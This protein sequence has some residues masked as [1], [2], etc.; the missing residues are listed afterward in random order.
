MQ[1]LQIVWILGWALKLVLHHLWSRCGLLYVHFIWAGWHESS[2]TCYAII[3]IHDSCTLGI[4]DTKF[5]FK[6]FADT[7]SSPFF[8]L[9]FKHY[10]WS[11]FNLESYLAII[12]CILQ[13]QLKDYFPRRNK[14]KLSFMIFHLMLTRY[15]ILVVDYSFRIY[16]FAVYQK[17]ISQEEI[18]W[19][20]CHML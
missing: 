5:H 10:V 11:I 1:G 14:M 8:T 18:K 19:R 13:P 15:N 2:A 12:C 20:F 6:S 3:L 17:I 7:S 9:T 16:V 4:Y